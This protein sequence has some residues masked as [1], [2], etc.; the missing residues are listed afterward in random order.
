[1]IT[2]RKFPWFGK[3]QWENIFFIHWRVSPDQ[4]SPYIPKPLQIDT[5]DGSAWLSAVCFQATVNQLRAVPINLIQPAIQLNIRTYVTLN[6]TEERGVYFFRI[7][8]NR[9]IP[10]KAANVTYHLPFSYSHATFTKKENEIIYQINDETKPQFHVHF[11][12]QKAKD[13]SPLAQFLTERYCIWNKKRNRL[14]KIPIIHSKWQLQR[15]E[16]KIFHQNLHPLIYGK[17]PSVIHFHPKKMAYLYPYE[18]F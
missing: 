6:E 11:Q 13:E 17:E 9:K 2:K 12:P 5:F 3:Q 18:R 7:L 8:L 10:V 14:I 15:A 4:L 16:A 1:M